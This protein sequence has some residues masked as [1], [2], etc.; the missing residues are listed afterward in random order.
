MKQ[1]TAKTADAMTLMDVRTPPPLPRASIVG[2]MAR[3]PYHE[4]ARRA[5]SPE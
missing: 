5:T 2:A 1:A 3:R 4:V